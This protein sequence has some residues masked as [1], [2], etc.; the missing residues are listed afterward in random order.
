VTA[1]AEPLQGACE[2]PTA[3]HRATARAGERHLLLAALAVAAGLIVPFALVHVDDADGVVYTVVARHLAQDGRPFDLRF[4]PEVLPRFREH[5]PFFFWVW[6]AAI[7]LASE[8]ALPWVGAA[9]GLATVAVAFAIGRRLAGPRAAFLGSVALATVDSFFR[10]QA[11]ARLDPPLTL[12]FTLSVGLLV[13]ARGRTALLAL[14]GLAAGL[15]VLVKGPPALGAPVAAA[16]MLVALGRGAELRPPRAWAAVT[17]AVVALPAAFLAYDHVALGGTWWRGYVVD[18]VLASLLGR[19][20]DSQH[21][22]ARGFLVLETLGRLG[23]WALAVCW[24]LWRAA[25]AP[26]APRARAA[27]ALAAW[28]ALVVLGYSLP[29]RAFWHYTMPAYVPLSLLAGLG[30]EE[31]IERAGDAAFRWTRAVVAAAAVALLGLLPFG[32]V[33]FNVRPCPLGPLTPGAAALAGRGRG[34]A[35][36]T[37]RAALAEAGIL[38]QHAGLDAVVLRAPADLRARPDLR[39]ALIDVA[40]DVPAGWVAVARN[41]DWILAGRAEPPTP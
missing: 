41:P 40:L 28:A 22:V 1:P 16:L 30:L 18:Q 25:R 31:A 4:L 27:W 33:T 36:V 14:G 6:A 15:G 38:A 7:R 20:H 13:C 3:G 10:Y 12:L 21:G 11:R 39:A 35:L 32:A 24:A 23:P 34:V 19:R 26:A 17:L 37:G 2:A 5:P 8:R 29:A 9:C